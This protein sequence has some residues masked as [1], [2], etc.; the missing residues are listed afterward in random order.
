[1]TEVGLEAYD[2]IAREAL[3]QELGRAAATDLVTGLPDREQF[4]RL[5]LPRAVATLNRFAV[6]VFDVANFTETVAA[7][8]IKRARR[9]LR[10]LAEA[11]SESVPDGARCARFGDDE[12]CAIIPEAGSEQA[13]R[14]AESVLERIAGRGFEVDVGIAE[15]PEHGSDAGELMRQT[16]KALKMAKRVG[17]S[18]IVVAR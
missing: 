1:V 8:E 10:R 4:N 13:Y 7:G 9:I 16:L 14:V 12:V 6:L 2:A 18:G 15:Y 3:E 11:V 17:G 5:L